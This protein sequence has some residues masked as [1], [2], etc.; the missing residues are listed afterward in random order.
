MVEVISFL[1]RLMADLIA[2][3]RKC[4]HILMIS[5]KEVIIIYN[6]PANQLVVN[7]YFAAQS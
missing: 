7:Y 3:V 2:F 6:L 4:K 5:R 1:R